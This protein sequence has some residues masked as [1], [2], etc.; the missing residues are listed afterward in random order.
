[1]GGRRA[2]WGGGLRDQ[3]VAS[4]GARAWCGLSSGCLGVGGRN[5]TA[6]PGQGGWPERGGRRPGQVKRAEEGVVGSCRDWT[7][8]GVECELR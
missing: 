1:M 3:S 8:R 5:A 4:L 2:S 6:G 7:G